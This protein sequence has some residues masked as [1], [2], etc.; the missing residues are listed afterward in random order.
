[1]AKICDSA[2]SGLQS[3]PCALSPVTQ[4]G[5]GLFNKHVPQPSTGEVARLVLH[6]PLSDPRRK[7]ASK[8]EHVSPASELSLNNN[9]PCSECIKW[10]AV[11][12][13]SPQ[14]SRRSELFTV[15]GE[16]TQTPSR[17]MFIF[18][19]KLLCNRSVNTDYAVYD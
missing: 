4:S 11:K 1:M 3:C 15:D 9:A 13:E 2:V 8:K 16:N 6:H 5:A 17:V 10:A 18:K 12:A 19:G 14:R 7:S